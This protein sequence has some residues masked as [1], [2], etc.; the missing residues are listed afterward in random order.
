MTTKEPVIKMK[1]IAKEF[2]GVRALSDINLEFY[3]GEVHALLGENGAGKSTLIKIISGIYQKDEGTMFYQGEECEFENARQALHHGISVIHQEL[4]IIPDLTVAENVFLGREPKKK[5]GLLDKLRM[6]K[7]T[8]EILKTMDLKISP[9]DVVKHL[10]AA[11][12]QMVEIARAVSQNAKVVI[13]DE[14]TSSLSDN[15]ARALFCIIKK[16][17][18]D[19]VA[20]IYISHRIKELFEISD[21]VSILRDGCYIGTLL[22]TE[23]DEAGLISLMVGR[24]VKTYIKREEKNLK[25]TVLDL[26]NV[27]RKRNF[28]KVSMTLKKGEIVG[29][30]GLIGAGRTEVL[31]GVFGAEPFD[32][33]TMKLYGKKVCISRPIDAI[34]RGIG[35]VPEDRR[36]QG[37]MLKKAVKYNITLP[38]IKENAKYGIVN[39]SWE[40]SS[41]KE[42]V[43]KLNIKTPSI[44]TVSKNLSGGNQQ[45]VVIAKW[46]LAGSDILLLDEPT[47][48][49]DVGAKLEIYNLMYEFTKNGGSILV[50]SSELV[51][52][53]G[54]CDR[55]YVMCEG[56]ITGCLENKDLTEEQ[57]MHL[58][59][60]N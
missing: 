57:I 10:S 52:L 22:I 8:D 26:E 9:A 56:Y 41:S 46:M 49:I 36:Q 35:L 60:K 33:G 31:R 12:R 34:R 11:K 39:I 59:S 3:P 5:S 40:N 45:K 2:P 14:P 25:E 54:I 13:M 32:S 28:S 51:E 7:E 58:A 48:G 27:S 24:E 43:K 18:A 38:S 50:V 4:S 53:L 29:I 30:A 42:Y 55:I 19:N 16:L 20:V 47:R 1:K 37:L 6:N 21:K 17:K 15:E 23:V 44:T